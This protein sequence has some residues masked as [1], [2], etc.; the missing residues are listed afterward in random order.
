[1]YIRVPL[2]PFVLFFSFVRPGIFPII[3]ILWFFYY[4]QEIFH[5]LSLKQTVPRLLYERT[6]APS[7]SIIVFVLI[8]IYNQFLSKR[9]FLILNHKTKVIRFKRIFDEIVCNINVAV[10]QLYTMLRALT[11][12]LN[13]RTD[14]FVCRYSN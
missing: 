1:M 3:I 6:V 9:I 2:Y 12:A 11:C 10:P 14:N 5:Y 13:C 7:F 4:S 8:Y